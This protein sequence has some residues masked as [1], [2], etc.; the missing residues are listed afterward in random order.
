MED[1]STLKRI[2]ENFYKNI[3]ALRI[4]NDQIGSHAEQHD[5]SAFQ[6]FISGFAQVIGRSEEELQ[7]NPLGKIVNVKLKLPRIEELKALDSPDDENEEDKTIDLGNEVTD[8]SVT[9][10]RDIVID[11]PERAIEFIKFMHNARKKVPLQTRLLRQGVLIN[12]VI[13]WETLVANLLQH[14]YLTNPSALPTDGRTLSLADLREIG[15]IE[16]AEKF[17]IDK[18]IDAIMREGVKAQLDAFAKR[19]KVNLDDLVDLLPTLIEVVQRRNLFVHNNGVVNRFYMTNVS[20]AFL[21]SRKIKEGD[22]LVIS[23][24]YLLSAIDTICICGTML[25]QQAWRKWSKSEESLKVADVAIGELVYESL[26]E[27]RWELVEKSCTYASKLNIQSD[28]DQ[29]IITMN[30][31]IALKEQNKI[32]QMEGLLSKKDWSSCALKFH[33]ALH[34]LRDEHD[35]MISD[36]RK[37]VAA[38]E[39]TEEDLSTWP[40]FRWFRESDDF[41]IEIN[42]LFGESE[43]EANNEDT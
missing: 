30:H 5:K 24:P 21:E 19:S 43:E 13:I 41:E 8:E 10:E 18:E 11:D 28:M 31:A 14:F 3:N 20:R 36:L 4:F 16:N 6:E 34:T 23:L 40:L 26:Q 22:D 27:K 35:E 9:E 15:S 2:A 39:I 37:A 32:E 25:I 38:E 7:P 33:V 17:L 12:L 1:Q 42:Y 29:R